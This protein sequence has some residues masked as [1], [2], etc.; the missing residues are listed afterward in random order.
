[1]CIEAVC[2]ME[3]HLTLMEDSIDQL[4]SLGETLAEPLTAALFLSSL[5]DSYSTL[6]TASETRPEA[7]LTIE[8][9]KN[10]LLEESTKRQ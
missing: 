2:S 10:K 4:S 7:D 8:L 9:V 5:P 1:M 6:I 3:S